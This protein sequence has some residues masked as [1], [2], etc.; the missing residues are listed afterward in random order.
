MGHSDQA[1]PM[2]PCTILHVIG[3]NEQLQT[4]LLVPLRLR[5]FIVLSLFSILS[6]FFVCF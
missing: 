4:H 1:V 3:G 6:F 5:G 2:V